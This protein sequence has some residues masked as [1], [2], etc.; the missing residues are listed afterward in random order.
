[1]PA[2][3]THRDMRSVETQKQRYSR[4]LAEYTLRQWDVARQA[5]DSEKAKDTSGRPSS[6][7]DSSPRGQIQ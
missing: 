4:E 7:K 2:T 6:P 5:M 3:A 1:M